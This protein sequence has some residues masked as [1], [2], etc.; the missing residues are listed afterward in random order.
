MKTKNTILLATL[1]FTA[2]LHADPNAPVPT[3]E[4]QPPVVAKMTPP[5]EP[6][7]E[8]MAEKSE[9]EAE[10][11]EAKVKKQEEK[12]AVMRE[13]LDEKEETVEATE[14][15]SEGNANHARD[16]INAEADLVISKMEKAI[17]QIDDARKRQN[18][19]V[20][21]SLETDK[22]FTYEDKMA[23]VEQFVA[24]AKMILDK[25]DEASSLEK[26]ENTVEKVENNE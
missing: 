2:L 19:K 26:A 25:T 8:K 18:G 11:L 20:I 21:K 15:K 4:P 6:S 5:A 23:A 24:S 10:A 7:P 12:L 22:A 17:N 13:R 1:G 9:K 3:T 16:L 14:E